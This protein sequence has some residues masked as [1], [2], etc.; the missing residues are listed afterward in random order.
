MQTALRYRTDP[1][2]R[3]SRSGS[4]GRRRWLSRL[5]ARDAAAWH[6]A[7]GRLASA[8]EPRLDR[9]VVA[10]RAV[11]AEGGWRLEDLGAALHRARERARGF[12][13]LVLHTDVAD[14]YPSVT[15]AVAARAARGGG[16][17]PQDAAL[18]AEMLEGWAALGHRGLPIGPPGSA[19]LANAV[20]LGVDT[21]LGA[22]PFLRW[23]DDYRIAVASEG[24]AAVVLTRLDA[25]FARLGLRRSIPKT[26]VGRAADLPWPG[27]GYAPR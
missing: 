7:A 5:S 11:F 27:N 15:P 16:A 23:V 20:L 12:I 3:S 14:F 22:R 8:L 4:A 21:A 17:D 13:G 24:D 9:R 10:S 2:G 26:V 1:I 6:A 19:V 18:V 25:S